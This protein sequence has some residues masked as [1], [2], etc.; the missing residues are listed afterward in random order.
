MRQLA[1]P[2]AHAPRFRAED[3]IAA[4]S[5]AEARA[6]LDRRTSW[7]GGRLAIYGD[8]GSGKSHLLHLWAARQNAVQLSGPALRI[9]PKP[10]ETGPLVIDDADAAPDEAILLHLLNLA[11][12]DARPVLLAGR[13]AP[14]HWPVRLPDLASRLRAIS[15]VLLKPAEDD[16]LQALLARLLSDRQLLLPE[17]LQVWMLTRLPRHPAA[18]REAVA[19]LD[20]Q[21]LAEG[22]RVTRAGA[23]AV[24]AEICAEND[25]FDN[26]PP[27]LSTNPAS[28]L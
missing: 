5:N 4:P 11:A 3:F 28:L 1:L 22:R 20:R 13:L 17:S 25:D 8:E 15:A 14:A 2:F 18:L 27:L 10:G 21:T 23:A 19:R 12:E 24:L 26:S 6:W 16:L 9:L 7:P